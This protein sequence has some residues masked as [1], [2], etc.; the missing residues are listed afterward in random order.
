M[1]WHYA[2]KKVKAEFGDGYEYTVVEVHPT[3]PAL[4]EKAVPHT[5]GTTFFG[6]TPEGLAAWLRVAADDIEKHGVINE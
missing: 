3:L 6:S 1:G 4:D 5:E 2:C